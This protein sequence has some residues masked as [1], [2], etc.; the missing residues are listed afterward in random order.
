MRVALRRL[1]SVFRVFAPALPEA[2]TARLVEELRWLAR[3]LG[4]ARDWNVFMAETMPPVMTTFA[5]HEGVAEFAKDCARRERDAVGKAR[6]AVASKRYHRMLL[7]FGV[8]LARQAWR[9]AAEPAALQRLDD[10]VTEFAIE[11]LEERYEI[12]QKRA[13]RLERQSAAQLHRLRIAIKNLRYTLDFFAALFLQAEA[14]RTLACL[15]RLQDILGTMNDA[16]TAGQLARQALGERTEKAASEA[17]GIVIGWGR[18][19]AAA[20]KAELLEA[21]RAYRDCGRCWR[22]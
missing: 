21:W 12:V 22:S 11:M 1:R 4:P 14:R 17:Y 13:R 9:E 16:A 6:R 20:L 10:T 18:G 5:G 19:R 3:A 15:S 7:R 8:W 2:A